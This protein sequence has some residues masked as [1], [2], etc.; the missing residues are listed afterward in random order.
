VPDGYIRPI[1]TALGLLA[2]ALLI[3]A[4]AFF[5]GAEFALVAVDPDRLDAVAGQ[6]GRRGRAARSAVARLSFNLSGAQLG[7]TVTSLILGFLAE[8]T[9]AQVIEPL[10]DQLPESIS[11]IVSVAVALSLVT[12]VQMVIGELV[13]KGYAVSQPLRLTLL[14][15]PAIRL[16]GLAFGWLIT[17]F[18]GA[19]DWVVR[20]F[21]IEPREELRSVR[22]IDELE[23]LITSSGHEGTLDPE[24]FELLTR[25]IRFGHKSAVDAMVPRPDMATIG[26]DASV[27]ELARLALDTGYSRFP[28]VGADPDDVVGV[29]HAKDVLR[30][31]AEARERTPVSELAVAPTFIPEGRDLES[32]LTEMRRGGVHLAVV[33]DEYGA[34]AGLVTLEDLLEEIVGEI[35]DEYDPADAPLTSPV[36]GGATELE[37]SMHLDEVQEAAGVEL[38]EGPY[39][40]L[41]GFILATLGH[42]PTEGEV[43]RYRGWT[44]EV[45]EM[46]RRR[47]AQVRVTS[48]REVAR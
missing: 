41:A 26:A 3:A 43:A 16:Y 29:V 32:L 39:E 47:I 36:R 27:S 40:T 31:A 18:N 34:V 14:L 46:D 2:V 28:V 8:P 24:S 4:N 33:A 6:H 35:E 9:V 20:R 5:V 45:L 48:P 19:A 38:P 1:D 25:T 10:T 21:G 42:I 15:A 11:G 12:A 30:V 37:G 13:P 7:I 17:I 44:F 23:M 22:T